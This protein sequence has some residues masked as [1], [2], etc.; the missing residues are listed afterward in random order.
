MNFIF[1]SPGPYSSSDQPGM[2]GV[3]IDGTVSLSEREDGMMRVG[4]RW[5]KHKEEFRLD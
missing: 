3:E 2:S 4:Q 1:T 5:S